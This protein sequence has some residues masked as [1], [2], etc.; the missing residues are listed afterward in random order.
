M[1]G[2]QAPEVTVL[3]ATHRLPWWRLA[4]AHLQLLS[5]VPLEVAL[6]TPVLLP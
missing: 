5:A 4:P 3:A 1:E 2:L 6:P